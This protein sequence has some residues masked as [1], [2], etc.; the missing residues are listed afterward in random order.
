MGTTSLPACAG[1]VRRDCLDQPGVRVARDQPHA[2]QAARHQVGEEHVPRFLR[3]AGG[4]LDAEDLTVPVAVDAGRNEHDSVDDAPVLA[5]LHRQRVGGDERERPDLTERASTER[6]DLLIEVGSH[7]RDLRRG[8][9]RDPQTRHQFV[10]PARGHAKQIAGRHHADQR[11]LGPLAPLEQPFREVGAG[12]KLRDRHVD[13]PDSSV[14][15]AV[16]V[17]ITGVHPLRRH[18]PVLGAAHRVGIDRQQRIDHR[19]QQR[20]HQI[21]RRVGQSLAQHSSRVDHVWCGHRHVPFE[22]AVRGSLERSRDD[23]VLTPQT[24]RATITPT[25]LHHYQGRNWLRTP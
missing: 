19:G 15:L 20:A 8:Q 25:A 1:Q 6:R 18:L 22:S 16:P 9:R 11:S 14:Q 13:C 2:G 4:D 12:A 17:A 21:R 3:L 10:H 7:P 5:D 23:R 24:H